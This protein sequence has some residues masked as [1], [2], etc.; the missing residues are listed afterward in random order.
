MLPSIR[1]HSLGGKNIVNDWRVLE[2]LR[3][4]MKLLD[5]H[6]DRSNPE[7]RLHWKTLEAIAA[8]RV[9]H[10][11][12]RHGATYLIAAEFKA[13]MYATSNRYGSEVLG[14]VNWLLEQCPP[15]HR[16]AIDATL[17]CYPSI[18]ECLSLSGHPLV[19]RA[20]GVPEKCVRTENGED[21]SGV[22]RLL[23][24]AFAD[25][26]RFNGLN[27]IGSFELCSPRPV[28]HLRIFQVQEWKGYPP[29]DYRLEEIDP[30]TE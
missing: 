10:L 21:A 9:D 17:A 24:E 22:I 12:W 2:F 20:D 28:E 4:A 14:L 15:K 29:M 30:P 19:I 13:V 18:A 16:P 11:N 8:Q 6:V 23:V 7:V 27:Q 26:R 3:T 5:E 25:P 1:Q